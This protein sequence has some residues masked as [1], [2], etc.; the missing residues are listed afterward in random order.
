MLRLL[1]PVLM[2]TPS[3]EP[4]VIKSKLFS[5]NTAIRQMIV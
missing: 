5:F 3:E 4:G 2:S 1:N